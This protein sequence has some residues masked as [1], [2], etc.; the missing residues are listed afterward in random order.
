M[1]GTLKPTEARRRCL[2]FETGA[3]ALAKSRRREIPC[4]PGKRAHSTGAARGPSKT[5]TRRVWSRWAPHNRLRPRRRERRPRASSRGP[6]PP[7]GA[8]AATIYFIF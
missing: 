5:I 2:L 4:R 3:V 8:R 7:H 6:R 1:V